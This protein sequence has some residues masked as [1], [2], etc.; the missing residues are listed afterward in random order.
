VSYAGSGGDRL[1]M[2]DGG[3]DTCSTWK[4]GIL[5]LRLP[6]D[7]PVRMPLYNGAVAEYMEGC[8]AIGSDTFWRAPKTI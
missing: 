1:A 6:S 7:R 4:V 3:R 2:A 8:R 5:G